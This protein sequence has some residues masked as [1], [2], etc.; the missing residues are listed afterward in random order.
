[1]SNL[2]FTFSD[3][4]SFLLDNLSGLKERLYSGLHS[5]KTGSTTTHTQR[6]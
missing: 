1:M 2:K 3:I 6:H 4:T 5:V